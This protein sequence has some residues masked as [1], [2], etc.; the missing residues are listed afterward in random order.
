MSELY[1]LPNGWEW[2]NLGNVTTE[3]S[4][5]NQALQCH[6]K[7]YLS[8]ENIESFT[9]NIINYKTVKESNIIGTC[10][11]FN[12]NSVLYSKLRPYLNKV[13]T[14]NFDGVG[15]TELIVFLPEENLDKQYLAHF[16]RSGSVVA[17]IDASSYGAKMP[18][19]SSKFLRA[20][21]IPIPPLLEQQRIVSKLDLLFKKIDKS[22]ELHQKNRDEADAF[23]GSVLNEVFEELEEKYGLIKI[24]EIISKTK[25]VNPITEEDK[26]FTYIDISSVNNKSF[27]IEEPKYLIG[28]E[29]PSRAKKEVKIGDIVFAT[30]RPNLKNIAMVTEDYDNPI[31]STGFCILR[32]NERNR[33]EYLFFYLLTNKLFEQI[34]PKIRGAQYPAVSDKDLIDCS[35]PNAPLPI[36]QKVVEYLDSISK[37]MEKVTSIQKE[38]METLK[39]LKASIL[40]KAF[41]GE[42]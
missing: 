33:N 10:S 8:L 34:E 39:A 14:P 36:Q 37:K 23:M 12:S 13:A 3:L 5:K 21:D 29:A 15:T 24:S 31:A 4:S 16:L 6:D 11:N 20:L 40:D 28:K 1:E 42:L 18:R 17:K 32:V 41:R 27:K 26:S 9:G 22:I 25:N 35:L 19:A 38:R 2:K 7:P 30:T